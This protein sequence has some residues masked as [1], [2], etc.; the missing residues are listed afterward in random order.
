MSANNNIRIIGR[1]GKTPEMKYGPSGTAVA[2]VSVAVDTRR[3]GEDSPPDWF[4]CVA[5]GKTAEVVNDYGAKGRLVAL[6]GEMHQNR[7]EKDGEP[8][9]SWELTIRSVQFLD[10][11]PAQEE[12]D[13]E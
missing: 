9:V 5:F 12:P 13:F 8:R 11:P 1:L 7:W 4:S 2:K 10:K 3:G 6:D